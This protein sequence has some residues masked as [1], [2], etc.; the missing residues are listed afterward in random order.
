MLRG[1]R[2]S[3]LLSARLD[4]VLGVEAVRKQVA[5]RESNRQPRRAVCRGLHVKICRGWMEGG[6]KVR[7]GA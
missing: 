5:G 3:L 1:D 4:P 2:D 6:Q 7:R